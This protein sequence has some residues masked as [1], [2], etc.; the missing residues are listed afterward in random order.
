MSVG[1]TS[2]QSC[3]TRSGAIA[4][5]PV[6]GFASCLMVVSIAVAQAHRDPLILVTELRALGARRC[7]PESY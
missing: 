6:L 3:L 1:N 5:R 7:C 4:M 2:A